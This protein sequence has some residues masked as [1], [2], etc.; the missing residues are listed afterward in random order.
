MAG[1]LEGQN[2]VLDAEGHEHRQ[3][4][5]V[6]ERVGV[7]F[8]PAHRRPYLARYHHVEGEHGLEII[9]AGLTGEAR[10]EE[11]TCRVNARR[12][13]PGDVVGHVARGERAREARVRIRARIDE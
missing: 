4:E 11:R 8:A 9:L 3:S 13:I 7:E 1:A 5:A 12:Q 10:M 2:L 6:P